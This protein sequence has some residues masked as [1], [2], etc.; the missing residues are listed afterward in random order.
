VEV[1]DATALVLGDFGERE[2]R[3]VAEGRVGQSGLPGDG[4]AGRW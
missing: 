2:A 4:A 1:D 3:L